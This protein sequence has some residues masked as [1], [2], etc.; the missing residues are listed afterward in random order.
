L[1]DT[2]ALDRGDYSII[3]IFVL[4][5]LL[6]LIAIVSGTAYIELQPQKMVFA[7]LIIIPIGA[8]MAGII[9]TYSLT[10][11]TLQRQFRHFVLIFFS[12]NAI[13]AVS[14]YFITHPAMSAFSPFAG[15][16]RN[17]TI[18]TAFGFILAPTAL[19]SRA[20]DVF[21]IRK[22]RS[23]AAV[24]WAGAVLP[25]ISL[26][27][28]LSP[29]PVFATVT[30]AGEVTLAT[31]VVLMVFWPMFFLAIARYYSA[32]RA[33]R[34]RLDL[35]A[36]LSIILWVYSSVLIFL[37]RGPL[38]LLELVWFS[39]FISGELLL[40][41]ASFASEIVE[42]HKALTALVDLRTKQLNES[43]REIE[44]YLNIWGHKIGN[45]LQSMML[46]LEMFSTGTKAP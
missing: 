30:D 45:L 6:S 31:Y 1:P 28:L 32:W 15:R 40:V 16:L 29:E 35:A 20:S 9:L 18:V 2:R 37:Q 12:V 43:K 26:W 19:F 5:V 24:I 11:F 14:L 17:R 21:D 7:F 34:N 36:I 10:Q 42:P 3:S 39:A 22:M 4:V 41:S 8:M 38:L 44:F 27:F 25:L 13:L 33:E 46:Y 23:I